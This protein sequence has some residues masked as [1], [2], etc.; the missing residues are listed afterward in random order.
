MQVNAAPKPT[1]SDREIVEFCRLLPGLSWKICPA[2]TPD[3]RV[4]LIAEAHYAVYKAASRYNPE[5]GGNLRTYLG[6]CAHFA[7]L[8]CL[9]QHKKWQAGISSFSDGDDER[10]FVSE[11]V[12][13]HD[14]TEKTVVDQ[15]VGDYIDE[16]LRRAG[17]SA[18]ERAIMH[19][20]IVDDLPM[21]DIAERTGATFKSV[22]NS[23]I[24]ARRKLLAYGNHLSAN[25]AGGAL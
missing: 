9:K 4:E 25:R 12:R 21:L 7:M 1:V 2:V 16:H 13:S 17:L 24:R 15:F 3:L 20:R 18:R 10:D 19:L 5:A 11:I 23:I 6:I 22:D 14:D 8:K